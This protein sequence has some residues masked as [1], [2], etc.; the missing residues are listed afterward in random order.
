MYFN[1]LIDLRNLFIDVKRTYIFFNLKGIGLRERWRTKNIITLF[2]LVVNPINLL[3]TQIYPIWMQHYDLNQPTKSIAHLQIHL[4]ATT[5]L[6]MST[7]YRTT[8]SIPPNLFSLKSSPKWPKPTLSTIY[9]NAQSLEKKNL[10]ETR[11]QT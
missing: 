5:E 8:S 3:Y 10:D 7:S 9:T 2:V 6:H 1:F 11:T 4:N